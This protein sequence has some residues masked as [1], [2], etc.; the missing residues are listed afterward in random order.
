MQHLLKHSNIISL[1]GAYDDEIVVHLVMELCEGSEPF[2]H[3]VAR[4]C[5][6]KKETMGLIL[7]IIEVVQTCHSYAS[8]TL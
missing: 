2:K 7:T 5:N 4:W 6:A 3:I 8:R 1:K